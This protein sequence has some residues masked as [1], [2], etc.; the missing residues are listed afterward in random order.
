ML[1]PEWPELALLPRRLIVE[2]DD[3][4]HS[5]QE[6]EPAGKQIEHGTRVAASSS[7]CGN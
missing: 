6:L 1:E 2:I 7:D 4:M 5:G 3:A